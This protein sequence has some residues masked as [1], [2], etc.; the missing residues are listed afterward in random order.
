MRIFMASGE[1]LAVSRMAPWWRNAVPRCWRSSSTKRFQLRLL[2]LQDD[3]RLRPHRGRDRVVRLLEA[4]ANP[5]PLEEAAGS[6]PG[7]EESKDPLGLDSR[8]LGRA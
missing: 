4:G 1:E 3:L 7:P 5:N 6:L 2:E 8:C